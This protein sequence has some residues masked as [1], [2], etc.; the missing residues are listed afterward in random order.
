MNA[1]I[2]LLALIALA[3]MHLA[4]TEAQHR[5]PSQG[6]ARQGR[7]ETAPK[8]RGEEV[9]SESLR[10]LLG[11]LRAQKQSLERRER[12][13]EQRERVADEIAEDAQQVLSEIEAV[14]LSVEK[15]IVK[16]DEESV[17][18]IS[19]LA[20]VYAEMPAGRAAPLL[21]QLDLDLAT[22][23][24]SKMKHKKSAA[25]LA[26]MSRRNALR[27]SNRVAHPLGGAV[28]AGSQRKSGRKP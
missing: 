16:S 14:Q 8:C 20:K 28:E 27:V 5:E 2:R 24:L 26:L 1:R 22:S 4:S 3:C 13:L 18:R 9:S 19:R 23:I 15:M 6:A 21:E 17:A 7:S 11:E 12:D 25:V 10:Q